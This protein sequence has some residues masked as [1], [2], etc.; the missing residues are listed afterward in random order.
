MKILICG[1]SGFVGRHLIAALQQAGHQCV[2][3][4]RRPSQPGDVI[5]DYLTDITAEHWVARLRGF[6]VVINAVGLLRDSAKVPMSKVLG[7]APSAIFRAAEASGVKRIV[8]FSALGVEGS[9]DT[10]YF[11]YRREAEQVLFALPA[12]V[13]RLNLRPSVIYGEDGASAR[14]FR[15]LASLPIH[16]LPGGG[17]QQLQ[18]VH[19]DDVVAAVCNWLADPDAQTVTVNASGAEVTTM[20][21]MLDSY[22]TQLGH[23]KALHVTVPALFVKLGAR[24]GDFVPAS[25]LCSD[26]WKMLNAGNTGNNH[27]FETLLGRPPQA[28]RTFI[29]GEEA[30]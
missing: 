13:L 7:Q 25:P 30:R 17:H 12:S 27:A 29:S 26:T 14:M 21:Q 8:N 24:V 1:A 28:F 5:V 3:G 19:I 4:V 10:P 6:D 15:L 2:R 11:R 22:R 18:P 20:R 23:G 16:G 9:V